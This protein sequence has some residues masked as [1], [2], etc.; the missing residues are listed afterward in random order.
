M[1]PRTKADR[2]RLHRHGRVEDR[3]GRD[4]A[5]RRAASDRARVQFSSISKFGLLEMAG[6]ACAPPSEQFTSPARAAT[7]LALRDTESRRCR[8]H[9]QEESMK[10]TAA[11]HAEAERL[12][13]CSTGATRSPRSS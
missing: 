8:S 5:A 11:V 7:A 9:G 4:T 1:R 3:R 6:S 2:R 12:R 13:S 10:D